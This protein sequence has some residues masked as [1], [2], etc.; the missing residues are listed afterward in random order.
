VPYVVNDFMTR[1]LSGSVIGSNLTATMVQS[2]ARHFSKSRAKPEVS[3]S[4]RLG[5]D[6]E[7]LSVVC[8]GGVVPVVLFNSLARLRREMIHIGLDCN[9][10][11]VT[12]LSSDGQSHVAVPAQVCLVAVRGRVASHCW[13]WRPGQLESYPARGLHRTIPSCS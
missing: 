13:S 10:V 6:P 3:D 12:M 8:D 9:N 2:I 7:A 11:A 4:A 5:S 1:A